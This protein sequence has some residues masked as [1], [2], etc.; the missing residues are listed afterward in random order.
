MTTSGY[1]RRVRGANTPRTDVVTARSAVDD[2]PADDANT[3]ESVRNLLT[4]LQ[5]G[6]NRARADQA[7]GARTEDD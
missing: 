4:G 1:K 3:A 6:A 7:D 5:A 2:E